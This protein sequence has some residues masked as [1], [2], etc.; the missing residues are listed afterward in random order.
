MSRA[1][2]PPLGVR[3]VYGLRPQPDFAAL[4][5]EE[6]AEL[7]RAQNEVVTSPAARLITG[8][9]AL[10]SRVTWTTVALTDRQI[11]VR[12]HRPRRSGTGPLPL[13]LH[14]HGGGYSGTAV[15]CDWLT[16]HLAARLPAV[17]VS[18]EHRLL[19]PGV[20]MAAAADDVLS[21]LVQV[22]QHAST[23]G[24]DPDRVALVGESAGGTM[25]ALAAERSPWLRAQVLVNPCLDLTAAALD[26]PSMTE[27]AHTPTISAAEV[28]RFCR[29]AAPAGTDA[30][31]VSPLTRAETATLPSTLLVVPAL[32][33]LADQAR[34]YA[35]R[36]RPTQTPVR[37]L[38]IERA[39]HAFLSMPHLVP[40]AYRARR[41]IC[42]FLHAAL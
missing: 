42:S 41:A 25:T 27:H 3:L 22:R 40:S 39:G 4:S 35:A 21:T 6:L 9:P 38:E 11:P 10:G 2:H 26:Y 33:P 7:G 5:D 15:Q 19:G 17:V 23:W 24:V 29:L 36:V 20:S 37:L 13:V 14:V 12:V 34:T 8:C 30:R 16:S 32:D 1:A 31:A 28:Q 18:V